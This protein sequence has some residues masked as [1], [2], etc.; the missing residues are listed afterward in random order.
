[1]KP[2]PSSPRDP[3]RPAK[4]VHLTGYQDIKTYYDVAG[5]DYAMWSRNFNMHFG[6]FR[7]FRDLFSLEKMLVNMNDLVISSL[8]IGTGEKA[9]IADLG[10]GVGTVARYTAVRYPDACITGI[11]ISDY[12]IEKGNSLVRRDGLQNQ[13]LLVKDNFEGLQLAGNQ[14]THAYAIESAC[15]AHGAGK[16]LFV[17]EMSR[18]LKQGGRFC[19]ADGFLKHPN[20][21]PRVFEYLYQK[22]IRYWAL[23]CFG[24]IGEVEAAL[25]KYGLTDIRIREISYR[26]APSVAYVPWTCVKFFVAELWKNRSLRM[27]KERWHNVYAPV[28]GMLLGLFR[29]HFGYYIITGR[30]A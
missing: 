30:K 1:M 8:G 2:A 25:K 7:K 11:T 3:V 12:Q 21:L 13:V 9:E 26:I 27:K 29:R 14:F 28:I 24:C 5:P 4:V 23:P 6:Y 19:I 22:I 15:H 10:C 20:R 18:V 17:A 16:E